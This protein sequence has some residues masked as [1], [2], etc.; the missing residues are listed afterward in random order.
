MGGEFRVALARNMF[1][2]PCPRDLT[3][4]VGPSGSQ[5]F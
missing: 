5:K 1:F 2:I 3:T 4:A